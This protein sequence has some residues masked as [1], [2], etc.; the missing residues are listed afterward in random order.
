MTPSC[1]IHLWI[2]LLILSVHPCVTSGTSSASASALPTTIASFI[3]TERLNYSAI[4]VNEQFVYVFG[5]FYHPSQGGQAIKQVDVYYLNGTQNEHNNVTSMITPRGYL[6]ALLV[7]NRFVVAAGGSTSVGSNPLSVIEVLDTWTGEWS[8]ESLT[9]PFS[10]N[11]PQLCLFGAGSVA[12]MCAGQITVS[13]V[14]ITGGSTYNLPP[15]PNPACSGGAFGALRAVD[16]IFEVQS[17][18]DPLMVYFCSEG[19]YL[20][21]GYK[22]WSVITKN[23]FHWQSVPVHY[24]ITAINQELSM[25][26]SN[27]ATPFFVFIITNNSLNFNPCVIVGYCSGQLLYSRNQFVCIEVVN[28][29]Q[30][31][32]EQMSANDVETDQSVYQ[33]SWSMSR[34]NAQR[35]GQGFGKWDCYPLD[36]T[37]AFMWDRTGDFSNLIT[38]NSTPNSVIFGAG[39]ALYSVDGSDGSVENSTSLIGS[40]HINSIALTPNYTLGLNSIVTLSE[41]YTSIQQLCTVGS[42][43]IT[44]LRSVCYVDDTF[45]LGR[46]SVGV[47]GTIYI[48]GNMGICAFSE[49]GQMLWSDQLSIVPS[50]PEDESSSLAITQDGTTLF[51][52]G[53]PAYDVAYCYAFDSQ[54]GIQ[55]WSYPLPSLHR[56]YFS[57][58]VVGP[59]GLVYVTLSS[60]V[61]ALEATEGTLKWTY[62]IKDQFRSIVVGNDGT[63]FVSGRYSIYA[64]DGVTGALVRQFP[65]Q[66]SSM[67]LT[68]DGKLVAFN[69]LSLLS[70]SDGRTG[71]LIW[72]YKKP[73]ITSIEAIAP[74]GT[75]IVIDDG[76]TVLALFGNTS[77]PWV[78]LS[79]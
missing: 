15:L 27:F 32:I 56:E 66:G 57:N 29:E 25:F 69:D 79:L 3:L 14:N 2:S 42:W 37:E 39:T 61:Y 33:S 72:T 21:D 4:V 35:S 9:L 36:S 26:S 51:V 5:G 18:E 68:S 73:S 75:L 7:D 59:S 13:V 70:I 48:F 40:T 6:S 31:N 19:T 52:V 64:I 74:D 50:S 45:S 16:Q 24:P 46:L 8:T 71:A 34:G 41:N 1:S 58:V 62:D 20:L 43:C 65:G 10:C 78:Q 23:P 12:T 63:V 22:G 44:P 77:L 49:N 17:Y 11:N 76:Y 54:T 55:I 53:Q 38:T 28:S 60:N 47:D 30:Q 67:A